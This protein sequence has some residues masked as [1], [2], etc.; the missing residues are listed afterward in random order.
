MALAQHGS[1]DVRFQQQVDNAETYL[2]PFIEK[3]KAITPGLRVM[4]IGCGEG[5]VLKPFVAKG[6]ICLGV[7]LSKSRIESATNFMAEEV[8]QGKA[9]FVTK[10][11]YDSDFLET[12]RG[13]F[14]LIMLKDTIEHIPDQE[15]FIPYLKHFLK[16]EGQI[17][18][19]F[20]PWQ[21][22]F[23]GHQ[24]ICQSKFL[25]KLPW[26]HLLPR[27]LYRGILRTF[28]E[29]EPTIQE[30]LDIKSTGIT[31]ERFERIIAKESFEISAKTLF[32]FNPI[33]RY[34]FGLTPRVQAGWMAGIPYIRNFFTTAGW[35]MV[36]QH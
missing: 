21:M 36:R 25:G 23:G 17:F 30:L 29:Y 10:N 31:L 20:P 6:A 32:L 35:Y 5:G 12:Y 11:V 14:D 4:E 9:E 16:S 7:D 8:A 26:F 2:I 33:Y 22:P 19:G 13:Q 34:K 24:Q 18:F 27:S 15:K 28:K 3:A 1:L